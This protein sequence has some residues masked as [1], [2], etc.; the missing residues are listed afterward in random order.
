MFLRLFQIDCVFLWRLKAKCGCF[1]HFDH[2]I[3]IAIV[4]EQK[5]KPELLMNISFVN[6]KAV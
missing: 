3:E 5:S 1:K 6:G 4:D 2:N